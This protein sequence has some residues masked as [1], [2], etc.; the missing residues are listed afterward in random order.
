[1]VGVHPIERGISNGLLP[2]IL[3][4]SIT[5][6]NAALLYRE[7]KQSLL[8]IRAELLEQK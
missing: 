2:F 4:E 8:H 1:M 6:E 7:L 3:S 5:E